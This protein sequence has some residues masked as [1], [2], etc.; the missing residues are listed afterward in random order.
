[1]PDKTRPL[2]V[3]L[4]FHWFNK[5]S[6]ANTHNN[7]PLHILVLGRDIVSCLLCSYLN[8]TIHCENNKVVPSTSV[9]DGTKW[10]GEFGCCIGSRTRSIH[11]SKVLFPLIFWRQLSKC[12]FSLLQL[13]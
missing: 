8:H 4:Y 3:F 12:F 9:A 6:A 10:N 7:K 2:L 11:N 1:S 13:L 5:D